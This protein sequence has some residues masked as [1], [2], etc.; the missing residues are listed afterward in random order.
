MK[1]LG[2]LGT[3]NT[4]VPITGVC[5]CEIVLEKYWVDYDVMRMQLPRKEYVLGWF[6]C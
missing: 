1:L 5:V 4:M 3:K 6:L 2:P